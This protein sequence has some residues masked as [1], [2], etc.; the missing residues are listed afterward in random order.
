MNLFINIL[1]ACVIAHAIS[2]IK[3]RHTLL[4]DQLVSFN[5]SSQLKKANMK[6]FAILSV[7][8]VFI[9]GAIAQLD[10][11]DPVSGAREGIPLGVS[12]G[13]GK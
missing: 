5:R 4:F 9:A 1:F 10:G 11:V 3:V 12:T 13:E 6:L 2:V 8:A 7:I